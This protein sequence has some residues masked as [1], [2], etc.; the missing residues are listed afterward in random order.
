M[1]GWVEMTSFCE[2]SVSEK[3]EGKVGH[4][5]DGRIG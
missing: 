3:T 2:K 1:F 4:L 5:E